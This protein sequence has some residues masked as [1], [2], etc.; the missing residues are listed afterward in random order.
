MSAPALQSPGFVNPATSFY[1][2]SEVGFG[3]YPI[4]HMVELGAK[5]FGGEV[6]PL[7]SRGRDRLHRLK[8]VARRAPRGD[9]LISVFVLRGPGEARSLGRV[10]EFFSVPKRRILWI[11][12]SFRTDDIPHRRI[13][14]QFDAVVFT[15]EFETPVYEKIVGERA[16]WLGF[17]TDA[18]DLGCAGPAR[19]VDVLRIGRQPPAWDDDE[20][21]AAACRTRGLTFAGRPPF[22]KSAQD[23]QRSLMQDYCGRAK[24]MVAHS[25]L[26]APAPYTHPT[27]EYITARWTDALASGASIAGVPP[28]SELDLIDCPGGLL[29]FDRIDLEHNIEAIAAAAADWKPYQPLVNHLHALKT[30]DWRW[31]FARLADYLGLDPAPLRADLQRLKAR[32][33]FVEGT[34]RAQAA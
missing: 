16:L 3:W 25:N 5:L 34:L 28:R 14:D 23:Q 8:L 4:V 27:K 10:P 22:I 1:F 2:H 7:P 6:R 12:E 31:R 11:I 13:L 24:F 19:P 9:D 18:L 20:R 21:A 29:S 33:D 17:G 15:Q 32:I 30:L 26:A